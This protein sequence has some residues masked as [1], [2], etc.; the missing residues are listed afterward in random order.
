MRD[1]VRS[2]TSRGHR[3][4]REQLSAFALAPG[5]LLGF[6]TFGGVIFGGYVFWD[7]DDDLYSRFL[8][9]R[10]HACIPEQ[11]SN[12]VIGCADRESAS[13]LKVWGVWECSPESAA[14]Q[15]D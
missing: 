7:R 4:L 9:Y 1:R 15:T 13:E 12:F 2:D 5:S 6:R 11:L 14:G 8:P 10:F 3:V